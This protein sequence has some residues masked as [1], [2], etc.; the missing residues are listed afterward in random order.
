MVAGRQL[1][2]VIEAMHIGVEG[3][4]EYVKAMHGSVNDERYICR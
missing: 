4:L 2:L 1:H 3:L